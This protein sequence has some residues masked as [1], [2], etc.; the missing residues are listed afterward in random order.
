MWKKDET[1]P[2]APQPTDDRTVPEREP[3]PAAPPARPAPSAA[4]PV[5]APA[6]RPAAIGPSITIK[7]EVSGEE[8]LLIQGAVEGS[9]DLGQHAVVVGKEGR[10]KANINGRLVTVEGEVEGDLRA[11]E[12]IVLRPSAKVKGDLAAPRVVLEDGARFRG[13]VEMGEAAAPQKGASKGPAAPAAVGGSGSGSTGPSSSGART[14]DS[15]REEVK[16]S[17]GSEK[18]EKKDKDKE[19]EK[20]GG[21]AR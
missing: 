3:R 10:V 5:P 7:G 16:G 9:V 13:M 8:D 19:K 4:Q 18:D 21:G 20:V 1:N 11:Q 17:A 2:A 12:Q 15:A 6:P 14:G